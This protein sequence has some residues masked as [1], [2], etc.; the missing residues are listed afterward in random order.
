MGPEARAPSVDLDPRDPTEARVNG[1]A[2][3]LDGE[4]ADRPRPAFAHVGCLID[5]SD[6]SPAAILAADAVRAPGGRLSVLFCDTTP[7]CPLI[8]PMG[9]VWV[10]DLAAIRRSTEAWLAGLVGSIER[11]EAVL[12]DGPASWSLPAWARETKADLVVMEPPRSPG[13]L[14]RQRLAKLSRSLPCPLLV[15]PG[16]AAARHRGAGREAPE[17]ALVPALG[18]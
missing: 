6:S 7:A 16:T 10:P 1:T 14:R 13:G 15:L 4:P 12:L 8:F 11:A 5:G 3:H 2:D 9:E 17:A 18:R